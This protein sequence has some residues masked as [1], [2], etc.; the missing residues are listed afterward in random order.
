MVFLSS[1]GISASLIAKCTA[2]TDTSPKRRYGESREVDIGRSARDL[3]CSYLLMAA[4]GAA[5]QSSNRCPA[6]SEASQDSLIGNAQCDR[7]FTGSAWHLQGPGEFP[8][9]VRKNRPSP[10][11][12]PSG[13]AGGERTAARA[14]RGVG[15]WCWLFF[16][17][18]QNGNTVPQY[19][20][21]FS[22]PAYKGMVWGSLSKCPGTRCNLIPQTF[23][24]WSTTLSRAT[25]SGWYS[26]DAKTVSLPV[27]KHSVVSAWAS[28]SAWA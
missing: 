3:C 6:A 20:S 5:K 18:R 14:G 13:H 19:R 11:A 15:R 26:F 2:R 25:S 4:P 1:W 27:S 7:Q 28:R 17:A 10:I 23:K 16:S 8:V 24:A 12:S 21:D 9:F 22:P